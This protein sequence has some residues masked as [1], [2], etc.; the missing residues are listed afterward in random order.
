MARLPGLFAA[1]A[2]LVGAILYLLPACSPRPDGGIA[3][4]MFAPC[5]AAPNCVSSDAR[6]PRHAIAPFVLESAAEDS[7]PRIRA[8]ILALPR[9][10][11]VVDD[12][13]YLHAECRS[14]LGFTDDLEIQLR[15][16]ENLLAV[17]SASRIG[18]YDFGVNRRRIE[19]L[20]RLLQKRGLIQ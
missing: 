3:R 1:C 19:T 20:R 5:P 9:T 4:A 8:G 17:R 10:T 12:T 14:L 6:D 13:T 15:P 2:T 7:W 18:Y 16:D 11:L